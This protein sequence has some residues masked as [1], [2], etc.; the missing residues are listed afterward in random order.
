MHH[1]LKHF[2]CGVGVN[3]AEDDFKSP[4][5]YSSFGDFSNSVML[6]FTGGTAIHAP[7]IL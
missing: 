1:L 6:G 7:A 3:I 2:L 5:D 4:N